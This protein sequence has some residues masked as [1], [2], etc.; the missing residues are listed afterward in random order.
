[1][2]TYALA[3]DI[4]KAYDC[5]DRKVLD[6]VMRYI[7]LA[8]NPFYRLM[9]RARD[10]GPTA[11]RS[12]LTLSDAFYTSIGIKQGC[13]LSPLLFAILMSGLERYILHHKPTA[14]FRIGD[15]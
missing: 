14:G 4:H 2:P 9:M 13:P 7:G 15:E 1:M 6:D 3:L 8:E 5:I 10:Y 11:V 12:G